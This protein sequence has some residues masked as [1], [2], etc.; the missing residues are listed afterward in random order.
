MVITFW[1]A[2]TIRFLGAD[3]FIF[4]KPIGPFNAFQWLLFVILPFG[5]IILELQGFYNHPLQKPPG[6]SSAQLARAAFWLGSSSPPARTSSAWSCLAAQSCRCSPFL[7]LALLLR[8][9][10]T[11][12]AC[13]NGH[14]RKR[15][16]NR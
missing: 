2:H 7:A 9:R 13:A 4:D 14:A 10:I 12:C 8:E 3:W 15:C 5:P 11:V 6:K 16:A 1:M